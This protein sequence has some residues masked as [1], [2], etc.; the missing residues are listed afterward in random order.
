MTPQPLAQQGQCIVPLPREVAAERGIGKYILNAPCIHGHLAPRYVTSAMCTE[1]SRIKLRDRYAKNPEKWKQVSRENWRK[2]IEHKRA[3]SRDTAKKL[4]QTNPERVAQYEKTKIAK[5]KADAIKWEKEKARQR[6]KQANAYK[7]DPEKH[8]QRSKDYRADPVKRD[9]VNLKCREYKKMNS[10]V[11]KELN[12]K[13]NPLRRA[14]K[15]HRTPPW[16]TDEDKRQMTE[17]YRKAR[18]LGMHVDHIIPLQGKKV[19]G[20]HVPSN[21]QLLTPTENQRKR[22]KF[23][24]I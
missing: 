9:Q 1:C 12:L 2:D 17:L 4:R 24:V 20:L 18:E 7:K 10:H 8:K 15:I 19:S 22:D 16:L 11:I 13:H 6:K 21:L 23:E 14:A 5:M 3:K